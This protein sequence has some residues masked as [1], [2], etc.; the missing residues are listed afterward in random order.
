MIV[1]KAPRPGQAK[2]RLTPPLTPEQAADVQ[3]ALLLDT[4]DACRLEEPGTALLYA[5]EEDLGPLRVLAGDDVPL[6]RQE[7]RGLAD[8]LRLGMARHLPHGPTAIVSSDVP[9]IPAGSLTRAFAALEDGA[10]LVLGPARD[11]G[12]WLIAMAALHPQ[13]FEDIPWSTPAVSAVTIERCRAAGLR[14]ESLELW[15]DVDTAI[16]LGFLA[17]APDNLPAPRTQALLA[18]LAVPDAPTFQLRASALL[19]GSPW[20]AV[21]ADELEADDGRRTAYTYLAT[22]RAVFVVAVTPADEVVLVRQ[23]HHPVR[24][25]TLE[26]P[27]GSV[28]DGESALDAARRELAEEA[29]AT[30]GAW[31]HLST[32]YSSSAH[33][34]LRSDAFLATDVV[35]GE[36]HPDAEEELSTVR[37]PVAQALEQARAGLFREGQTALALLLAAPYLEGSRT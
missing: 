9:G 20:R 23:Y 32:F 17:R 11:G 34:S 13:A 5:R 18:K 16:D 37:I 28:E 12:Y 4:L 26:V 6:V 36:P 27:A 3:R 19:A 21:I 30:A 35:L 31:R 7:G 25:W 24:D 15:R 2:T 33:L 22:P 14:V 10:D 29:G 1:A 8:A